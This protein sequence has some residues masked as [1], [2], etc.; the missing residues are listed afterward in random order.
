[1]AKFLGIDLGTGSVKAMLVDEA[2]RPVSEASRAYPVHSP[3]PGFAEGLPDEW[4]RQTVEA[5]RACCAG[6][7]SDVAGIGL[8]GQA[9]GIVPLDAAHKVLRPAILW[10]DVR[11]VKE[12]GEILSLPEAVRLPLANPVVSGMAAVALLWMRNNEPAVLEKTSIALSPKD[13]LRLQLTGNC[14]TEPSDAS[15][16]LLYDMAADGWSDALIEAV[17]IRRYML[18]DIIGSTDS[19]GRLRPQ[20]AEMLGLP[21]G[22]P[23]A[24]G[25]ADTAACLLGL[26]QT[27]PGATVL[28]VGS[29]MQI[30]TLVEEITP[31]IQ[32]FYNTYRG[33]GSVRYKMAAM[34]NGGTAFEWARAALGAS[35]DEMYRAAFEPNPG[36]GGALFLPYVGGERAPLLD[37]GASAAW[38][39]MRLGCGRAQMIRAVFEGI[40]FTVRDSWE[41]MKK[42]GVAADH[43]L[44]TG[45]GSTDPRWRQ[46]LADTVQLPMRPVVDAGNATIG[47]AYLGGIVAGHWAGEADLPEN[48]T[49][50]PLIEPRPWPQSDALF[51]RF[52]STYRQLKQ[53]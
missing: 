18:P 38:V 1:M 19:G 21:V 4:W 44:L 22:I 12:V 46:L 20:A 7:A 13:W 28:Q 25:L 5:V 14:A 24:A 36:N 49:I 42:T 50:G 10:P 45:G 41:A 37:P 2:G 11:T 3:Q 9:H 26:G 48:E 16:T 8:S 30:M 34:Q 40:A 29:G 52:R 43:M 31:D 53:R 47:A 15:M 17:G 33:C 35:W 51:E 6:H 39:D 32:P 23:I 27:Q